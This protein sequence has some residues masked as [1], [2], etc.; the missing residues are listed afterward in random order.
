[1]VNFD[2]QGAT[3]LPSVRNTTFA[4]SAETGGPTLQ[5]MVSD[6]AA[7]EPLDTRQLGYI[8]G[9]LRSDYANFVAHQ[10]P[11]VFFSDATGSCY[12]TTGDD[13]GIVDFGKLRAQSRTAFRL[14]TALADTTTPPGF[15]PPVAT[16]ATYDDAVVVSRLVDMGAA[17]AGLFPSA[18]QALLLGIQ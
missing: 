1:Y 6:A 15:S 16:L 8:F 2:I 14:V 9:Q 18:D 7:P 13:V 5:S 17:D 11:T 4:V 10:V 12:H 3:L